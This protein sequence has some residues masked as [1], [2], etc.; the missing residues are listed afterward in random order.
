VDESVAGEVL[1]DHFKNPRGKIASDP[2]RSVSA[3]NP[4]CGDRVALAVTVGGDGCRVSWA[5][6]GC[7]I[8]QASA[9]LMAQALDGQP[10]VEARRLAGD[11]VR[12]L[13]GRGG[14]PTGEVPEE[15]SAL[16]GVRRHPSRAACARLAWNLFLRWEGEADGV[17]GG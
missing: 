2:A 1:L 16:G 9:S 7:V 3:V 4:A 10:A 6:S 14:V 8:S 12:W 15:L 17:H 5:G 11:V 13:E